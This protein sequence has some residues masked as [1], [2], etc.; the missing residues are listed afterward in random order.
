LFKVR[1]NRIRPATDNKILTCWNALFISA[2]TDAAHV[3]NNPHWLKKA[4]VAADFFR[5]RIIERNGKLW[6]NSNADYLNNAGFLDDYC[7]LIKSFLDVYQSTLEE[8]WLTVANLLT[9][10]VLVHFT[11]EDR[12]FF[13]LSSDEEPRLIQDSV[14]L[15]DNVIPASNSQM[16][17]NLFVLGHL[18]ENDGYL[19][20]SEEMLKKMIPQ[21]KRNPAFHA[22][23]S[24]LLADFI[25]GPTTINI[26][27]NNSLA[28]LKEFAGKYLPNVIF[29][30]TLAKTA[31]HLGQIRNDN[32]K[33]LIYICFGKTCFNPVETVQE[34]LQIL[35][36][37]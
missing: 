4:I 15:T 21:I 22:N 23:W 32:E 33:T 17:R 8:I 24:S 7:F 13:N 5:T 25:T 12:L 34:A 31:P 16:A 18:L 26:V 10:V 11:A 19:L 3:F 1:S 29:S 14:E 28:C 30:G 27:G 6:R 35:G 20:R 9:R 37:H 36:K 2:L